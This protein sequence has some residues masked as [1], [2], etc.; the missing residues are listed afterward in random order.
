MYYS[1][2]NRIQARLGIVRSLSALHTTLACRS[3][4][5]RSWYPVCATPHPDFGHS[6]VGVS[7]PGPVGQAA[8]DRLNSGG[9]PAM[10]GLMSDLSH[11]SAG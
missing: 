4:S 9:R 8:R 1:A 11:N 2:A 5:C 7:F 6:P 10:A 3:R